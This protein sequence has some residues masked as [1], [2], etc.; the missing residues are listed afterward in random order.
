MTTRAG[1]RFRVLGL[2]SGTSVDGIDVAV[3]EL[4]ADGAT[5]VL[6]PLGEL[7]VPYAEELREGLL[8][9]LPPRPSSAE[10]LTVLDTLVGQ[11]FAEAASQGIE[12][13]GPV[14][15]IASLGQTVYHWVSGGVAL[16]TLQLGQPAWIA[17]RTGVPVIA[18][19]RIRD[20]TAG[21]QGA[22]LASTLD[23]L[24]LR[25]LA[26]E[27]GRPVAALNLGGIAN[28]TVVGQSDAAV[29]AYDTGPANALLDIAAARVTDGAQHADLDGRLALAGTVRPDLL[30]RLVADPYFAA[31]APKSTGKEHFHSGYLD[32]A[33]DGLPPLS[34]E[35]L[36]ATLTELTAVTV[37][38]ECRRHGAATV[39]ASG[40]GV[41][42]PAVLA[43]LARHLPGVALRTSDDLGLPGAG[44]E[45]YLTALLG[46]LGW[47]GVPASLPSATGARGPRLLGALTPG[48]APLDLPAPLGGTV[49]R[50]RVAEVGAGR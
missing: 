5:V 4:R 46:W 13:Y 40:G 11:A 25:G 49:T 17:E 14:D 44:K 22:P 3:A 34:A 31:A 7:D 1:H 27:T 43:A 23:A 33:L 36:L 30:D 15:V 35:D 26:E 19:L 10:Q 28:I 39:V 20:I 37:A 16:G 45:A 38:A 50:L 8:D 29:L 12:R 32:A 48:A 24:W 42:N 18:D 21:G 2:L 9:A 41:A 6:T 47:C